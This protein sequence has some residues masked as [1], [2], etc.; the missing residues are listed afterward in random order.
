MKDLY[1]GGVLVVIVTAVF[2]YSAIRNPDFTMPDRAKIARLLQRRPQCAATVQDMLDTKLILSVMHD[3]PTAIN[4]AVGA[5][6]WS[7][8]SSSARSAVAL[9]LYCAA[10]PDDGLFT[11]RCHYFGP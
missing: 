11:R 6:A 5:D 9:A 1:V 8:L 7:R 4:V 10:T 2:A 3:G